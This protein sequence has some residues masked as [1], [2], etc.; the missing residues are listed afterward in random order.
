MRI[1]NPTFGISAAGGE[2]VAVKPVDWRADPIALFSNSKPNA[3]ELLEGIRARLGDLRRTDNI[4]FVHK[5]SASQ[6]APA[7]LIEQ[8]AAKYKGALLAIAD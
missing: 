6:G 8:V 4:D 1:V 3:R 7:E 2:T 5:N